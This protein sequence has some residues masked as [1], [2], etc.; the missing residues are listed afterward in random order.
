MKKGIS[1]VAVGLLVAGCA[2][3]TPTQKGA[4]AGS[5]VGAGLGAIIGHQSVDTGKGALVGAAAGGLA[6]SLLGDTMA[7][8]FCPTCGRDYFSDQMNCPLD[9]AILRSKGAPPQTA[10]QQQAESSLTKFCPACGRSYAE[11]ATYCS[12][13]GTALKAK[14]Q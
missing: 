7:S 4:V 9:G 2:T 6:G 10:Q 11:A 3:A 13:D 1:L 14:Q 12:E 8:K 5:A